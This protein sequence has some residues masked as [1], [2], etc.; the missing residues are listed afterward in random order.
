MK[1]KK[2]KSEPYRRETK[3]EN[4]GRRP[5]KSPSIPEKKDSG[6]KL[7]G[8]VWGS[9]LRRKDRKERK[10]LENPG[11][12]NICIGGGMTPGREGQSDPCG[13]AAAW[14]GGPTLRHQ[15]GRLVE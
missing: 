15:E 3:R 6:K 7:E 2:T 11:P 14:T 8:M 4:Y 1:S 9:R 5:L 13:G 10:S 12:L